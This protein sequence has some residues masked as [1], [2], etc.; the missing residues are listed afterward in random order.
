MSNSSTTIVDDN[1]RCAPVDA[2]HETTI[3]SLRKRQR[4]ERSTARRAASVTSTMTS[5]NAHNSEELYSL[6]RGTNERSRKTSVYR[7]CRQ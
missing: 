6:D 5:E 4:P 3:V 2:N 7:R 1:Q